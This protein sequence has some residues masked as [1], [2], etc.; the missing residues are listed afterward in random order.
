MIRIKT[1]SLLGVILLFSSITVMAQADQLERDIRIAERIIEEIFSS[2]T[3]NGQLI[4]LRTGAVSGEYLSGIGVH[5]TIN[6]STFRLMAG[7]QHGDRDNRQQFTLEDFEVG[8]MEYLTGYASQ[9][10]GLN[11]NEQIQFTFGRNR[12]NT[13]FI[14]MPGREQ[15]VQRA[16][17]IFMAYVRV[18]DVKRFADDTLTESDFRERVTVMDLTEA[19]PKRDLDIFASV[20]ETALNRETDS[21]LRIARKPDFVYMP[22]FGAAFELNVRSRTGFSLDSFIAQIDEMDLDDVRINIDLGDVTGL[23]DSDIRVNSPSVR[24]ERDSIRI[25]LERVRDTIQQNLNGVKAQIAVL[26]RDSVSSDIGG[27]AGR[28]FEFNFAANDT[29]DLSA[30]ATKMIDELTSVMKDY[31]GTLS[32]LKDDEMV[33]IIINWPA[34]N[35]TLPAK[36]HIR[37]TKEDLFFGWEPLIEEVQRR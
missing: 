6:H 12:G 8:V 32:S 27:M 22:G 36:T 4:R 24:I 19:E 23:H 5:F 35:Q 7:D 33:M 18:G 25:D 20:I 15:I 31:A 10:R 3:S 9:L 29:V 14:A 2:N 1:L 17:G 34:R 11:E 13:G 21:Q 30:D 28:R 16:H 26:G 37:A